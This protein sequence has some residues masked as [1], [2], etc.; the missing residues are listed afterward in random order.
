MAAFPYAIHSV[1]T[2]N[3]MAIADLPKNSR[4]EEP[5][6]TAGVG[7]F[8][9]DPPQRIERSR[10][11]SGRRLGCSTKPRSSTSTRASG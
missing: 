1:L 2:V 9:G 3:G 6:E 11:W 7:T 5:N 4:T 8:P 10:S